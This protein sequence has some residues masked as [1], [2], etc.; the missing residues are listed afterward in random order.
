[1]GSRRNGRDEEMSDERA[2]VKAELELAEEDENSSAEETSGA[3]KKVHLHELVSFLP[4]RRQALFALDTIKIE[5]RKILANFHTCL[6]ADRDAGV[7][8][9]GRA[10]RKAAE[11]ATGDESDD[12]QSDE[13]SS[14]GD[15]DEGQGG[16]GE[17]E[18]KDKSKKKRAV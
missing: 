13:E 9:G 12:R 3:R 18:E 8:S 4:Q 15:T 6:M 1:M 17:E 16:D 2:Q 11:T 10:K 5:K 7:Q 14:G